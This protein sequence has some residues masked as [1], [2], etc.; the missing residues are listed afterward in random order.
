MHRLSEG[1]A[2]LVQALAGKKPLA[3]AMRDWA[4]LVQ[5][6]G[7]QA[8]LVWTKG[9]RGLSSMWCLLGDLQAV[10]MDHGGHL[11]GQREA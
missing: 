6:T 11:G 3:Q 9:S 2:R 8:P 7:G 4:L 1:G 5:A 10:G